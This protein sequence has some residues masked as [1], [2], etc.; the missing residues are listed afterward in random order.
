MH[1]VSHMC[2]RR[3]S[4][5]QREPLGRGASR[6]CRM[7]RVLPTVLTPL[8]NVAQVGRTQLMPE[9]LESQTQLALLPNWI[10][11]QNCEIRVSC[12]LI[13]RALQLAALFD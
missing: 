13:T 8:A 7:Y 5:L 12:E 1:A 9:A 11:L 2:G 3:R 10:C 4:T 6:L